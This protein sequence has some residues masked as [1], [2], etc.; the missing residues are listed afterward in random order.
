LRDAGH[1]E[2]RLVS[3]ITAHRFYLDAGWIEDGPPDTTGFATSYPM[4]KRL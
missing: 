4:R 2:A 1:A 3:T